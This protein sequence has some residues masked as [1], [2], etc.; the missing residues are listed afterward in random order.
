MLSSLGV[1]KASVK[2]RLPRPQSIPACCR[3]EVKKHRSE[4]GAK[5]SHRQTDDGTQE[6][7]LATRPQMIYTLRGRIGKVP[8]KEYSWTAECYC[9]VENRTVRPSKVMI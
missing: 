6:P 1:K 7:T 5:G 9:L 8:S 4:S 3:P 2:H